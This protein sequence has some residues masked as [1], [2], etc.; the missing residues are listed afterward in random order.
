MLFDKNFDT[1]PKAS[2]NDIRATYKHRRAALHQ[3]LRITKGILFTEQQVLQVLRDLIIES[4]KDIPA[5]SSGRSKNV[6]ALEQYCR[7]SNILEHV[8]E[9]KYFGRHTSPLL[10]AIQVCWMDI[11]L[12]N[13]MISLNRL[14]SQVILTHLRF[15]L[16]LDTPT[17]AF[18]DS[19]FCVYRKPYQ[20]PLF[21]GRGRTEINLRYV[22]RALNFFKH[23]C[24]TQHTALYHHYS[25]LHESERIHP[26]KRALKSD[27]VC[28]LG[29]SWR[30]AYG[31]FPHVRFRRVWTMPS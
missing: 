10:I 15:D 29:T 5:I 30:G 7:K 12:L 9:Y 26:W 2:N 1:V 20:E 31:I 23:Y 19:Q 14:F 4:Y 3:H 17:W 27:G 11:V 6:I 8:L 25:S 24:T 18:L 21:L 28:K 13:V 22:L 16:E